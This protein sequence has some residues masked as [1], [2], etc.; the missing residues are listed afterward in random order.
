MLIR[1]DAVEF[2]IADDI[3]RA[4]LVADANVADVTAGRY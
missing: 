3:Q 2:V 4:T 1:V